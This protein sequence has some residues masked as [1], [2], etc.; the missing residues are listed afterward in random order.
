MKQ[1]TNT[2]IIETTLADWLDGQDVMKA[3]YISPRTLQTLRDNGT[4]PYSR[5]G[6]KL[7]YRK[8]D[9]Q[10]ILADNYTMYKIRNYEKI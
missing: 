10:K 9:I 3:L 6:N 5:I 8:Q 2:S 1:T 4:I 7:Y